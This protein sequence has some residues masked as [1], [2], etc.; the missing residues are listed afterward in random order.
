MRIRRLWIQN[1]RGIGSLDWTVPTGWQLSILIGPGDSGKS[2]ILDAIHYV[3]GDRWTIPFADTDF[4]DANVDKSIVIKVLIDTLSPE[5]L[6]ETRF[7]FHLSGVDDTGEAHQDPEDGLEPALLVQLEVDQSLEPRWSVLRVDGDARPLTSTERR[8]F[9]TFKVDDRTDAQ[10]RWSQNSP[11]GRLSKHD[12]SRNALA[13]ASRAASDALSKHDD[14]ELEAVLADVQSR[15]NSIGGGRFS[16]IKPGLDTS[17]SSM[18]A[19]LALY[20]GLV[21]LTNF[22]LGSRRLASLA[23]QQLAAGSRSVAVIDEL[24]SGLEPHRAV[25]LLQFLASGGDY[26]QVFITT[27]SPIVVEQAD[28][29]ALAVVLKKGEVVSVTSLGSSGDLLQRIRRSAPSSFLSRRVIV[30]EGKTEH[31]ILLACIEAWDKER[32]TKGLTTSAGEG[33]AIQDGG[34]GSEVA[35][36]AEALQGLGYEA[37]TFLDNDDRSVD[38]AAETAKNAGVEMFRWKLGLNTEAQVCSQ[39]NANQLSNLLEVGASALGDERIVIDL[40]QGNETDSVSSLD[41]ATWINKGM[42]IDD[43]RRRVSEAACLKDDKKRKQKWFGSVDRGKELGRFILERSSAPELSE[44]MTVLNKM[45][46]FIYQEAS[47]SEV[48]QTDAD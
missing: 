21:P 12:G 9:S 4:Y 28:L 33:V 36:R 14:I 11:L 40:N 1:F 20:E 24:E 23:I 2:S 17:R 16:D 22:G 7:G 37:A 43:A 30:A 47:V 34:G 5:L 8:L 3:L 13:I 38:V 42:S 10:L 45:K 6:K 25:R 35:P 27:H 44:T 26:E 48:A 19:A 31:G 29:A 18:G 32:S 39:L 15:A 46:S 41:V